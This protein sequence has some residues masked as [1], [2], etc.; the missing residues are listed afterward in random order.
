[1]GLIEERDHCQPV[2]IVNDGDCP[3]R[4]NSMKDDAALACS[5]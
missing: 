2:L 3:G 4:F 5:H 1:M